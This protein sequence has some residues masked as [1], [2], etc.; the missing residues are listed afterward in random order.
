M[1]VSH[2]DDDDYKRV[3]IW[4]EDNYDYNFDGEFSD[5][6]EMEDINNDGDQW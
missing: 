3:M 6:F 2:N 5:D 1:I 4:I